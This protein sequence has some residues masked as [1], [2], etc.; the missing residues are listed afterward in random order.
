MSTV[1]LLCKL[2]SF[3]VY[4]VCSGMSFVQWD[5]GRQ[6]LCLVFAKTVLIFIVLFQAGI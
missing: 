1:Q 3:C 2:V 5:P 6:N 4:C